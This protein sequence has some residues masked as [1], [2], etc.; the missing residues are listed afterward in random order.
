MRRLY[1][2]HKP[3]PDFARLHEELQRRPYLTLQLAREE[4]RQA[5]PDGYGYSRF[6]ELYQQWRQRLDVVLRQSTQRARR[7]RV[8]DIAF[9]QPRGL[10]HTLV[11][12]LAQNSAWVGQHKERLSGRTPPGIGK[13]FLACAL[14]EK[15]CRDGFTAFYTRACFGT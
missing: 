2:S 7:H 12:S 11:R 14:A 8:E 4:Y 13:S 5:H 1:E 3:T 15:A 10:D 6:C 9:R